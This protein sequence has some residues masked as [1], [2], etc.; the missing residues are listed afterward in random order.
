[1]SI[2]KNFYFG[3]LTDAEVKYILK[4][5]GSIAKAHGLGDKP[6]DVLI[7][8]GTNQATLRPAAADTQTHTDF[9]RL[10]LS[11][12]LEIAASQTVN[13]ALAEELRRR[14]AALIGVKNML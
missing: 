1:M 8:L 3:Q 5:T 6:V 7:A 4:T 13:P 11:D 10:T 12:I 14:R 2:R 9:E